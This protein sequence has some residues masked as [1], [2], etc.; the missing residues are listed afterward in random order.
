VPTEFVVTKP[1]KTLAS[2]I[3]A[4]ALAQGHVSA[5]VVPWESTASTLN[6]AVTA[7]GGEG[8]AIEHKNLGTV[9]LTDLGGSST[10][11]V[12]TGAAADSK[13]ASV[14]DG[15]VNQLKSTFEAAR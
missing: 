14:F 2:E 15:F 10:R 12:A 13:L 3:E 7:V 11:V 8:W 6:M 1:T 4:Y 9:S 5:L